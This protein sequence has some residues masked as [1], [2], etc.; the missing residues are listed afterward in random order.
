MTIDVRVHTSIR[1][2]P[3]AAWDGLDGA[4]AAPFLSH[5][6]LSTLE[7]TR[8][9]GAEVGWQPH[10][11]SLWEGERLLVAA[12]FTPATGARLL[13]ADPADRPRLLPVLADVLRKLVD[14]EELSSA[15]VLFP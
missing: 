11:L 8:C 6:W 1:E 14:A 4:R 7:A 2:I 5:A 9:V 13:V 10:H 3:A 12:P 15:H